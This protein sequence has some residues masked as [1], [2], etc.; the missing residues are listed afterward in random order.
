MGVLYGQTEQ[1]K[2]KLLLAHGREPPSSGRWENE[3]KRWEAI[4]AQGYPETSSLLAP[5][6]HSLSRPCYSAACKWPR[7]QCLGQ[8]NW[9][10]GRGSDG[11]NNSVIA[12]HGPLNFPWSV[13]LYLL[14]SVSHFQ[15]RHKP[16]VSFCLQ[17]LATASSQGFKTTKALALGPAGPA[18]QKV[19][20]RKF[21][22]EVW[23]SS[24]STPVPISHWAISRKSLSP[25]SSGY[26]HKKKPNFRHL[27][28]VT[29][30]QQKQCLV[31]EVRGLKGEH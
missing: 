6:S 4:F 15:F 19:A 28:V 31:V 11:I 3:A 9:E 10:F 7:L 14:C 22:S 24:L 29:G 18:S 30:D 12:D 26:I 2:F 5:G 13:L 1:H 17:E 21:I 20:K 27:A 16:S 23:V 8:S 25:F